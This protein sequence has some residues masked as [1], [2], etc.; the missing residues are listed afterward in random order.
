LETQLANLAHVSSARRDAKRFAEKRAKNAEYR[1]E[2]LT[3]DGIW[4]RATTYHEDRESNA[5]YFCGE[6]NHPFVVEAFDCDP[7]EYDHS[8]G[9]PGQFRVKVPIRA[10]L[11]KD[12]K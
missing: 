1:L 10:L 9:V 6:Y 7:G 12:V 3:K 4:V 11:E 8:G 5:S 2:H